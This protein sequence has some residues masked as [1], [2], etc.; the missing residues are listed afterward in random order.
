MIATHLQFLR[1]QMATQRHV[2]TLFEYYAAMHMTRLHGTCFYVYQDV[3]V[4]HKIAA[5]FPETD[6]GIDLISEDYDHIAQVKYYRPTR[7]IHYGKLSTFLA[8]PLLIGRPRVQMT[9]L[10]TS[11]SCLHREIAAIIARGDMK[12]VTLCQ[13]DFYKVYRAL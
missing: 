12:D 8:S 11:H 9:L 4:S 6:K 3:P 7:M 13:K 2:P 10:R 5:G 1:K